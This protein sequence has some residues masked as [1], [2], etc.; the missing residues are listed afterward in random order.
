MKTFLIAS[1]ITGCLAACTGT[2]TKTEVKIDSTT[3]KDVGNKLDTL[4]D[5]IGEKAE[6]VWDTTK[7]KAKDLKNRIESSIE[8]SKDSIKAR[9]RDT[10][11][12]K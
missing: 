1:V 12:K 4:S 3:I 2:G 10:A 7:E 9:R 6:Q 8:R 11:V 5:R